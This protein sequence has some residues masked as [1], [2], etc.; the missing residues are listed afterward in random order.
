M[1]TRVI[2]SAVIEKDGDLL[3]GKKKANVGPYPNTWHLIGGGVNDNESLS[4]AIRREIKEEAGIEVEIKKSLGFSEDYEPNKHG[5][6][7]HY[8][9]L[10]FLTKYIFGEVKASDDIEKLVWIPKEKLSEIELNRP[11]IKLFKE[12][13]YIA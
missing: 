6:I 9:F 1:K 3:F 4:D 2:V 11:S 13:G 8:I 5:E 7:T 10:V 12:M